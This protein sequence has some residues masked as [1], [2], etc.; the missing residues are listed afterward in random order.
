MKRKKGKC[1]IPVLVVTMWVIIVV[2]CAFAAKAVTVYPSVETTPTRHAGDTADDTC[3]WIHPEKEELSLII[4]DDKKGGVCVWDLSGEER[5]YIDEESDM[6]NL[7]IRYN[8]QLGNKI[9]SIIG[10]V[11]E[12]DHSLNFYTVNPVTRLLE[13]VGIVALEKEKPYGG[14]M[15]HN[16]DTNKFYFFVNWKDGTVQQWELDGKSGFVKGSMVREFNVGSQVEGCVAD[17]EL[18]Y[19]YIGEEDVA[20]WK[21]GAEPS[22]GD[23]RTMV[24][25]V[26]TA[27]GGHLTADVEGVTLYYG[28]N[29]EKGYIICSSQGNSTFQVYHR[30]TNKYIGS[31]TIGATKQIDE[32]TETDGCDVSNVDL[33]GIFSKGIFV[34]HDHSNDGTDHS[35]HKLVKWEEIAD[36]LNLRIDTDY[37]PREG[38]NTAPKI[39]DIKDK[40]VKVNETL[41]FKVLAKDKEGNDLTYYGFDL[42]KGA[43]FRPDTQEFEWKP[44]NTQIG[45]HEIKFVVTDGYLIDSETVEIKVIP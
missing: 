27:K 25:S 32:V 26:D 16:P 34:A 33:G 12:S 2:S 42:P 23:T 10:V 3:I 7:D 13:P 35:N 37:D 41:K 20:L 24:D 21:Y 9:I 38:T 11:N 39:Q 19:F 29:K 15:Y 40:K 1:V 8:F 31:F 4:G 43:I 36:K 17:D 44:D 30:S 45:K 14:C 22:D 18:A 5:Q 28:K 6:N